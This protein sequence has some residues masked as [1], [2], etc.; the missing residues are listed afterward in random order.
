MCLTVY[1]TWRKCGDTT[2]ATELCD[3]AERGF[4]CFS[5]EER[6]IAEYDFCPECQVWE[7]GV[8]GHEYRI[9]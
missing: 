9:L 1:T 8:F 7:D 6:W 3:N 5:N 2:A 4:D